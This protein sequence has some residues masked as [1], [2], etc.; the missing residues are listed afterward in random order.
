MTEADAA[1][2]VGTTPPPRH[3]EA[4]VLLRDGRTAHIRP[5][6]PEDRELL[7]E[8]YS[9]VSDQS[10]YYRFFS[11]MPELSER[12]LDR[13]TRV[14]HRDRV[15]MIL[16]VAG[17]MIAVGRYDTIRPGY[18]EVAF[19]VE[20]KHQGRGIGQLL[21]EHLAQAG[22]ERGVEEFVAEVLPDN[23]A[24][25]HTFK[26]AGYQVK[27]AFEDGVMELVFR[28]DPTDTAIGVM[29]QREHRAEYASI[30]RFF[31]PK[32]V[33]IIGASRRQDTIGR[34]LVRHLVLGNFSGRIHVVNPSADSVAGMPAWKSV[35]EIPD[36]VDVAIVA[37]PADAVQ[38]V[39]LDCAA[40]GVHGLV[41]ISS[42]FA[43]TGEEGRMRQRRLV[44]LSR[45]YGLR[46]IG[47]N[48]LGIINTD[49]DVSLNASL[50]SVM[51]PRGR[52]GFFCQSGALGSAIL[53]KVQNRGLGLTTFVSAGNR[54][55]VSGNDLLQYWEED[56]A[57]EVVL[58]YLESIGNP[59]KFS[60]IARR[61]SRRKPIVAVRSGRS[62]Q[63]V[64]M[65][66]AVR[67]IGAPAQAVDAM[68][69]QAGII[70]VESLEEMF[71]VAQLLAHQPLPRGRR[72]AIVGNSDA[73]GLLAADA[74]NSVGLVV[75]RQEA[76]GADATAEDFEDAL[77]AAIDDPEVDAVAAI[78]IPPLN[79]TGAR[80][81]VANVLAAVGEQSDKPIVSTFLGTEG[82]P[83]LLRV[84]DVAGSSAGRGSVP[85]YPAVEAAVRAL[86]HV[87]EYAVWLRVPQSTV[88]DLP[89]N[90]RDDA[91]HLVNEV[92]MRHPEGRDLDFVEQRRLL[93]AYGI[94][95]WDTYAVE[96]VDEAVAAGEALDWDVVLKA[97]ADHLRDRPDLAHVWRNIDTP[98]EMAH[99]WTSLNEVITDP[100]RAGFVVQRNA[101]PGV[102]VTISTIEDPL[103]GPVLSFG[104]GG[105]LTE[106]LADRSY[107]I[108]PLADHDAQDM[109]REIKA[110]PLLFGYRGSEIVD[111][112]EIERLVRQVAQLQHDLPQVRALHLP[113]VL[114][115]A[116]GASVLGAS[117]RVEQVQDARSD[118]FV[119]RLSTMPGDT[120]PD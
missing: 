20:D 79:V 120:L 22:R 109:V 10:K 21:L 117:V 111:V 49:P 61:V 6:Q 60:R 87:V 72:V 12:D 62:S 73:L 100:E 9:R 78:F 91:R 110:S 70:Q 27:S 57:T 36:D 116:E 59:R 83:E 50:S 90:D 1:T 80:E 63:G 31:S 77:D 56:D 99:A 42:G 43:E 82:V 40:K 18:A 67:K 114:A 101:P 14:D 93:G 66:H 64:P 35:G 7:V 74:A 55:D 94:D 3:W 113:L 39:V 52:A 54:A 97:T 58:L 37:V 25:I 2:D 11:P 41:V 32:S 71:D 107:R 38:D 44:G 89:S 95:L 96:S 105:P 33:A 30:E 8:F 45:S 118:W 26:D 24:M 28:I 119:R 103:F 108:P 65:G 115:G 47:P 19:L 48:A 98:D 5:M 102:P 46:L 53:E 84:P 76:L 85:S 17:Q 69:R 23:Q 92:L 29:E 75:N 34:A 112:A 86:A 106:L 15:A 51:P 16:T 13:F 4:D 81:E 88:G 104:I 68:F